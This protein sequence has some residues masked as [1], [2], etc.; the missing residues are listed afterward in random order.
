M[1]TTVKLL[2]NGIKNNGDYIRCFY[3][4]KNGSILIT[5]RDYKNLPKELGNIKNDS[6][7]ITDYFENDRVL[8]TPTNKYYK[9]AKEAY[10]KARINDA[11]KHIKY[12]EKMS[13]KYT[14]ID[15]TSEIEAAKK[16]LSNLLNAA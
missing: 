16:T 5:A 6:D 3:T 4:E 11:K 12:L 1:K 14:S 10:E 2:T 8:I 7:M 13:A 9:A 15:Y